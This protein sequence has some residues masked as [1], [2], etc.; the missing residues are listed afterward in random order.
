MWFGVIGDV[1][2]VASDEQRAR[3]IA[4]ADT[5]P[6]KDAR[7]A[8]VLRADLRSLL[9]ELGGAGFLGGNARELRVSVEASEKRLHVRVRLDVEG[10]RPV[11]PFGGN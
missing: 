9:A 4:D 1:F 6:V 7:G 11:F 2:V 3:G 10:N 8:S 5:E